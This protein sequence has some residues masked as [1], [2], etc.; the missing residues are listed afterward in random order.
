MAGFFQDAWKISPRLTL[1]PGLRYEYFGSGHRT[2][3][4]KPLDASFYYGQGN[5]IYQRIAN[6]RL[7]RTT[8]A[9]GDY[10]N[11]YF[12]PRRSNFAP[13]LGVAYGVSGSGETVLRLG[14]GLF[15]ERLPGFAF[16]NTNPPAFGIARLS[17]VSLT[18]E[19]FID[20]YSVFP[21][22]T[23]PV[24]P[25]TVTHFDQDLRTAYVGHWNATLEHELTR[26]LVI[27]G[28]YLGSK[29]N[30]LYRLLNINRIGSGVF[31]S[32]P[33]ERLFNSASSFTT[34]SN[35]ADSSFHA[36][37]LRMESPGIRSIGL[38]FGANYTWSH[39][40]DNASTLLGDDV[41]ASPFPL[42]AFNPGLDKGSSDHDVRHRMVGHFVWQMPFGSTSGTYRKHL[43]SGWEISGIVSFQAGQPFNLRDSRVADRDLADNTRPRVTG[44]LP[45]AL[46]GSA[47]VADARTPN[48][49]LVLP[50]NPVRRP[51][52]SCLESAAPFGCQFSVNG[53]F[54]GSLGRS[55]FRRPGTQ[56]QNLAFIKNFNLP[57]S[58]RREGMKLQCRAEFYNFFNHSNLYFKT[59]T[60]NVGVSSFNTAGG[61]SVPGVLASFGTPERFPQEARQLV[62]AVKLIF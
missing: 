1:S 51:D 14:G 29:G 40:I 22:T 6:G 44:L 4:E 57:A 36:L 12:L 24:P 11:H 19:L 3:H 18:P 61:T 50:L 9:P 13:R 60:A 48:A 21:Q 17:A 33:E 26:N 58:G 37:E 55:V 28:A 32:R 23:I 52:G 54:N 8:D 39:S 7:L 42:D 25:S 20:P 53:P 46:R 15:F 43:F 41:S 56:F 10:H 59:D 45:G 49:F 38:Q 47:I 34:I 2:G 16:E 30:R 27:S 31:D 62:L 5:S 35:Q